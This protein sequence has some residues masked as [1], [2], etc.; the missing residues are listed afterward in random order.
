M[1]SAKTQ[2]NNGHPAEDEARAVLGHSPAPAASTSTPVALSIVVPARNAAD[3][4]EGCLHALTTQELDES[5]EIILVNDGSTDCTAEIAQR[6]APRVR[7]ISQPQMGAASARNTGANAAQGGIVLFTDAD[8]E[9]V[10]TWAATLQRAISL[11][12]A[13]AKGTYRTR[14]R[15]I[16]ARFVQAEYE[17]KYRR[18][19]HRDRIDFI[20]TY[21]RGH[22]TG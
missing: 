7:V 18:M 13:G 6:F 17:S 10:P 12:A 11:G 5:Y 20:D 19:E 1:L 21:L 9:P 22:C 16:V 15:N 2:S 3:T 4:L 14:Q 8:C